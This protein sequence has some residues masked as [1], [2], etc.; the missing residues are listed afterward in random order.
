MMK[1]WTKILPFF[2]VAWAARRFC[3]KNT[4]GGVDVVEPYRGVWISANKLSP[5]KSRR[6]IQKNIVCGGDVVGGDLYRMGGDAHYRSKACQKE[7]K[8]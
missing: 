8:K 6:V 4:L 7:A 1:S 3:S 5:V 2:M